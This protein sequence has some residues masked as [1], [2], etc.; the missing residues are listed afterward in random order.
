MQRRPADQRAAAAP[1]LKT[2]GYGGAVCPVLLAAAMVFAPAKSL[3]QATML[4]VFL[5]VATAWLVMLGHS[6]IAP[7]EEE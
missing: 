6:R 7:A 5:A 4:A 1:L 3:P 2:W